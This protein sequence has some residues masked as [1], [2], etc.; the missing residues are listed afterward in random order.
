[1]TF[2][3]PHPSDDWRA[4]GQCG[5]RFRGPQPRAC[6]QRSQSANHI[7]HYMSA[8]SRPLYA[9]GGMNSCGAAAEAPI[10]G[11]YG[12]VHDLPPLLEALRAPTAGARGSFRPQSHGRASRSSRTWCRTCQ[13]RW[14][15]EAAYH[16]HDSPTHSR[17]LTCTPSA[18]AKA[19]EALPC[20][21]KAYSPAAMGLSR[22][23]GQPRTSAS[24]SW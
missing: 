7:V 5:T 19:L 13:V 2:S 22:G 8:G 9:Q 12:V 20:T 24:I 15:G 3:R 4:K 16:A 6:W 14:R 11:A 23:I 21:A 1:M 10:R 17:M 18:G